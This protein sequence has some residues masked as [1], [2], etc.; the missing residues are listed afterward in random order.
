MTIK[1]SYILPIYNVERYLID[2]LD[3]IYAQNIP[4]ESFEVI[5]VNDCSPDCSRDVIL[6][7][8]KAHKNLV[9]IDH[10]ENKKAGGARN[11]G[12]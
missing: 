5:C 10:T 12:L 4:E 2:C 1:L 6:E 11:T 8:Q 7:Y 3:S 9:L